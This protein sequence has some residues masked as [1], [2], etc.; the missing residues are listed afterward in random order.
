[1]DSDPVVVVEYDPRWPARFASERDSILAA[2]DDLVTAVHHVGS[3]AVPGLA[4]KPI[5]DILVEA[6]TADLS[7]DQIVAM[8]RL[9]YEYRGEAGIAGRRFFRKGQPR[10]HHV[11]LFEHGHPEVE[12][13]LLFR[14]YLRAHPEEA[15]RYATLKRDLAARFGADRAGYTDSKDSF[16]AKVVERARA[17][18][19]RST[20]RRRTPGR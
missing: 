8:E 14:D 4:A 11:H 3:T 18:R 2:L 16:I 19:Q 20:S 7:A 17:R 12:K 15:A 9:G 5:I 6:R 10:S 1:M 13:H